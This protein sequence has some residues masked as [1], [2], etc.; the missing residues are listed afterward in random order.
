MYLL[1]TRTRALAALLVLA[2]GA[3]LLLAA[4][5]DKPADGKEIAKL[6]DQLGDEDADLRKT[7]EKKLFDIGEGALDAVNKAIKDHPDPDVRLRAILL[8]R[9]I[10]K[11][12][13][14]E[15]RKFTGHT[16]HIRHIVV[17][18]DG[19]RALTASMDYS[20]RVW[21]VDSGKEVSKFTGHTGWVWQVALSPDEKEAVSSGGL[22]KTLRRWEVATGKELKKYPEHP[23]RVYGAAFSADGKHVFSSGAEKDTIIRMFDADT[24]TEVKTFEGHTGWVWKLAVSPDGKR[25]ASAGMNDKTY[26][27]WDIESGKAVVIGN[28]AH[29]DSYVVGIAWTPDGKQLLTSGRDSLV[30]LWDAQTGRLLKTYKGLTDSA[31]A[32]AFSKDGKRF[33]ASDDRIVHVFETD[34]G[35]IIHRFEDHTQKVYA[36]AFLPD[37]RRALSAG[38]DNVLRMWGVPK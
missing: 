31:E 15:I 33:L 8:S 38:E 10:Q 14:G 26:R 19:K 29:D 11:G 4:D 34:S 36:V 24:A 5:D 23:S 16:G 7:A 35:K 28:D 18:K 2:V 25:L 3:G 13:F 9:N 21:D 6:I 12:A 22:D 32:V 30:K 1:L 27:I 17:S 20:A 37:G